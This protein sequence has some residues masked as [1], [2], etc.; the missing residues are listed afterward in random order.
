LCKKFSSPLASR[1]ARFFLGTTYLHTNVGTK[2][3]NMSIGH[4]IHN[5]TTKIPNGHKIY[6]RA[7]K[8][9]NGIKYNKV[10]PQGLQKYT[11]IV[12][13]LYA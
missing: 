10:F 13:Y 8:I 9:S 5:M 12:I 3:G 4:K 11:K 6:Q 7:I 2:T 1:V